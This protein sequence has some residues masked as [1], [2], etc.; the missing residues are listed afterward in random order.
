METSYISFIKMIFLLHNEA[1]VFTEQEMGSI[2]YLVMMV[3]GSLLL[4][5]LLHQN[6]ISSAFGLFL[7]QTHQLV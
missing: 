4:Q 5:D 1:L 6:R 3:S 7:N 2:K